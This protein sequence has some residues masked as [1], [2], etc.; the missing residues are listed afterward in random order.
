MLL[1]KLRKNEKE[2]PYFRMWYILPFIM[3]MYV[4]VQSHT[5]VMLA[6][7]PKKSYPM[8][9]IVKFLIEV[10]N[11]MPVS[12]KKSESM[13]LAATSH[14]VT[15][16]CA[17]AL[18]NG[19]DRRMTAKWAAAVMIAAIVKLSLSCYDYF[20]SCVCRREMNVFY[21]LLKEWSSFISKRVMFDI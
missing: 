13:R 18:R 16:S 1:M 5:I 12:N 20:Q 6:K 15:Q 14:Y 17:R 2:S 11:D 19:D 8:R 10:G 9:W 4:N 3:T 21:L 7:S